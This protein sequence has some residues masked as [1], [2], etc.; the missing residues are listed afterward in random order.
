MRSSGQPKHTK[1]NTGCCGIVGLARG[2]SVL[3][4]QLGVV[5][6]R[7]SLGALHH[8]DGDGHAEDLIEIGSLAL[9]ELEALIQ[10]LAVVVQLVQRVAIIGCRRGGSGVFGNMS[11]SIVT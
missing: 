10:P 5:R 2:G 6:V 11:A 9:V 1:L 4:W 3:S 7:P 8:G